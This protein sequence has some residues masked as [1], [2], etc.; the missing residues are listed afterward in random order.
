MK[1][2]E[3]YINNGT[4]KINS[5]TLRELKVLK[6]KKFIVSKLYYYLKPT[7]S[8]VPRFHGQP[9]MHKPGVLIRPVVSYSA[10]PIYNVDKYIANIFKAYV[11]NEKNNAKNSTTF[12]NYIRNVSIENDKIMVSFHVPFL[13]TNI[14]IIDTLNIIKEY[15]NNYNQFTRKTAIP[16]DKFLGLVDLVLTTNWYIFNS[17]FYQQTDDVALGSTPSS[18]TAEIYMQA[19]KLTV[20]SEALHP[21]KVLER[22]VDEVYSILKGTNLGNFFRHINNLHQNIKFT[23]EEESHGGLAFIETLLKWN[24]GKTLYWYIRSLLILT[25]NY[26]ATLTTKQVA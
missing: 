16:Q 20:I 14:I 1:K 22:F 13:Y 4:T 12:S 5:K 17:T 26:T 18:T 2:C 6:D 3:D 10:S 7:D 15:V 9:K 23:M 8:P 24:N 25:N 21:S 11:K 19:H